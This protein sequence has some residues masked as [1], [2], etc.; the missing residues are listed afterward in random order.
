M[1]NSLKIPSNAAQG[2]LDWHRLRLGNFTGSE[3][4]NLFISGKKKDEMFGQ[5]AMKYIH[6]KAA[7]RDL[8]KELVKDDDMFQMYLDIFNP[9]SKSM[10]WGKDQEDNARDLYSKSMNIKVI[11]VG[12]VKHKRIKNFASSPDGF[13]Y[14]ENNKEKGCLEI[15]CLSPENFM[16]YYHEVKDAEGLKKVEPKYYYQCMAHMSCTGAKW[17]DFV[18]Y[19]PFMKFPIQITRIKPNRGVFKEFKIRIGEANKII[20]EI[21][22]GNSR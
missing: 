19:N 16:M 21:L 15:K 13:I 22:N 12:L 17:C 11:T 4:G 14:N 20:N 10:E 6:K 18:V 9:S 3:V 8:N 2:S 5:V 7:E 1:K